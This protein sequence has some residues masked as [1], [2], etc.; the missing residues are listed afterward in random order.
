[1]SDFPSLEPDKNYQ[2]HDENAEIALKQVG[3]LLDKAMP[4]NYG[5]IFLM[6]TF[7]KGGNTFYISNVQRPDVVT[8]MQEWIE[9]NQDAN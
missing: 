5:F 3:D 1:M 8:M 6:T 4:E 7:G 2:V 9:A